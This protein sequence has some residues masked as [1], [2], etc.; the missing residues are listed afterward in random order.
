MTKAERAALVRERFLAKGGKL[1]T[2]PSVVQ[3]RR[4]TAPCCGRRPLAMPPLGELAC[5]RVKK[6]VR[7]PDAMERARLKLKRRSTPA[8]MGKIARH[9]KKKLMRGDGQSG[10]SKRLRPA[11]DGT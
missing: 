1:F 8:P 11:L 2:G 5:F 3:D 7:E 10:A 9:K 4:Q 6:W